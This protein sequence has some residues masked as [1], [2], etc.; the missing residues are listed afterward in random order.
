MA[1][2]QDILRNVI[3]TFKIKHTDLPFGYDSEFG[4]PNRYPDS[5]TIQ[6]EE[7]FGFIENII[8]NI[9]LTKR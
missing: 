5:R 7:R 4:I 3:H 6:L 9:C 1:Y 2:D 8:V